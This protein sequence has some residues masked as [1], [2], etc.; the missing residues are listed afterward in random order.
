MIQSNRPIGP[1][2]TPSRRRFL[3]GTGGAALIVGAPAILKGRRAKAQVNDGVFSLGVASGD[4][5]DRAVVLWT[6]LAPDPLNGGA[7]SVPEIDVQWRV[8]TDAGMANIIADGTTTALASR[9]Y[10]VHVRPNTLP[11]NSWLY[12]EFEALGEIS[13]LGRTR[14][15]PGRLDRADR[16]RFAVVSCQNYTQGFYPAWADI[17]AWRDQ[18]EDDL[19]CVIHTGDY[20]YEGGGT[21]VLPGRDHQ[22]FETITVEQYRARYA[23]YKLDPNLQDAHANFPF[24][25]TPDDHEVENNYAALI[26]EESS[27]TQGDEFVARRADAYQVYTEE[28]PFLLRGASNFDRFSQL[29]LFR[30]LSFGQLAD[31]HVLDTRQ[32]RTDQPA[33]D[34]FGSTDPDAQALEAILGQQLF[35]PQITADDA[36]MLGDRQ[37]AALYRNLQRSR[38]KWNILAQQVMVMNW[39]LIQTIRLFAQN[40]LANIDDI[41]NIDAWDGYQAARQRLFDV[42]AAA[43][44]SNPI[45]LTGDIHSAWA[46]NLLEDFDDP[47]SDV[48]GAEFVCTSI[49]STFAGIDPRPTHVI[50]RSGVEADNPHISYFNGL[51]R[52]YT[53]CDVDENRFQSTYRAVGDPANIGNPSPLALVPQEGDPVETDA[54]Y[55]IASGFNAPNSGV[56]LEEVFR[57]PLP[58]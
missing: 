44:P 31:I 12:Y 54:I 38:A 15:F 18:G 45:V 42:L 22:P 26:A 49:S 43:R 21:S 57:R 46:A 41:L 52:G 10:A 25:V 28:M 34:G 17:A 8:A 51:F 50:V 37:E 6:R 33:G 4:P 1:R 14:T 3:L 36:T 27:S 53:L 20:M 48:L 9:G 2:L 55:E 11:S 29:E 7:L 24:I 47:N 30:K 40:P 56:R 13:R 58:L 5:T 16:L 35:D 39:N 19:D 32:F 23:L